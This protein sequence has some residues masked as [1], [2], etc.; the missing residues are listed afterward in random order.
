MKARQSDIEICREFKSQLSREVPL[1]ALELFGSRARGEGETESDFDF[2][3]VV[4]EASDDVRRKIHHIAWEVA[5]EHNT[6]FQTV[7]MT[8]EQLTTRPE[9]SSLLVREVQREGIKI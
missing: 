5:F 3:V 2:L 6:V 8:Q 7:I 1:V 9:R 4:K